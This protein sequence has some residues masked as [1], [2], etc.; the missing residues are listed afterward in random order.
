MSWLLFLDESGHDHKNMPF[1]VRGGVALPASKLWSFIQSWRRL[2]ED[3]FGVTLAT[4]GKE[5]KGEKLLDRDRFRWAAQGE[6]LEAGERR[7]L[8]RAF[9]E[10]G[11]DKV[12]QTRST[13]TAYGQA[14]LEMARGVFD[15][16]AAHD[17]KLFASLIPRG[18]K[19][20]LDFALEEY[21]RKD[22]V[23]LLERF[24]YFLE[25]AKHHGL[26]VMDETEKTQDRR[27]VKRLEAYF[28]KTI[29][30]RNRAAWIVPSPLFVASDMSYAVQA[31]DICL[32][33]INWGF[34]LPAWQGEHAS[35][36]EIAEEFAPK[37]QR[38]QWRG[39]GVRD[40]QAFRSSGIVLV[41]DPYHARA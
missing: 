26:L 9:L 21:L 35:R 18:V 15:L 4:Y 16:L 17:A 24:Y 14:S 38:L 31:A 29:I 7:R 2:E 41:P 5:A 11:R 32:Y 30:G 12:G 22:Q 37:I 20:P 34:R 19:P 6:R 1:E 23:F 25:N 28:E 36:A 3:C 39:K 33:C 40:G 13:F 10:R 27:F 8:A